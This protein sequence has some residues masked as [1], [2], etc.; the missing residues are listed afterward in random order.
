LTKGL[1]RIIY[2]LLASFEYLSPLK[3]INIL[4][5]CTYKSK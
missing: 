4:G 2:D 3:T 1:S 5:T